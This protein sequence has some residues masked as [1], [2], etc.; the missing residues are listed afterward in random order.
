M[1]DDQQ[2]RELR[3]LVSQE[4]FRRTQQQIGGDVRLRIGTRQSITGRLVRMTPRA[5]DRLPSPALAATE[6]GPLAVVQSTDEDDDSEQKLRLTEPRFEAVVQ[7]P[8]D[9][10]DAEPAIGERGLLCLG[11]GNE[12]LG[13]YVYLRGS[14]WFRD[15]FKAAR[16]QLQ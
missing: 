11:T 10:Q 7:L 9:L 8:E 16:S 2:P 3:A 1:V 5:T 14:R 12:S 15:Q 6:G 4:D 13:Q